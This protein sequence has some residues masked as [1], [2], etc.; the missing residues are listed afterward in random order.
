MTTEKGT[1]MSEQITKSAVRRDFTYMRELMRL[2]DKMMRD[3]TTDYSIGS[4]I[5]QLSQEL[6]GCA[7]TLNAYIAEQ[8]HAAGDLSDER[9]GYSL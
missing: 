7:A 1:D 8:R 3:E 2:A 6:M 9:D 5:E 4:D